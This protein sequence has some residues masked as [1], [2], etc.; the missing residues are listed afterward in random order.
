MGIEGLV[1]FASHKD[2]SSDKSLQAPR[3][4]RAILVDCGSMQWFLR[5][6]ADLYVKHTGTDPEIADAATDFLGFLRY[7]GFEP[8]L[9]LDGSAGSASIMAKAETRDAR[10]VERHEGTSSADSDRNAWRASLVGGVNPGAATLGSAAARAALLTAA[11]RLGVV[12]VETKN[13][14]DATIAWAAAAAIPRA[15]GGVFV[16]SNDGDVVVIPDV[17]VV[18]NFT[19][20][21]NFEFFRF[22]RRHGDVHANLCFA[23]TALVQAAIV[24]RAADFLDS[25]FA[26]AVAGTAL[27]A[28]VPVAA[29]AGTQTEADTEE[30]DS[31]SDS[32]SD[33]LLRLARPGGIAAA[34]SKATARAEAA[35]RVKAE[36]KAQAAADFRSGLAKRALSQLPALAAVTSN[37]FVKCG[38]VFCTRAR[39]APDV[40]TA[41]RA[42]A[43]GSHA[44]ERFWAE[45]IAQQGDRAREWLR[46]GVYEKVKGDGG[47]RNMPLLL[48]VAW[49]LSIARRSGADHADALLKALFSTSPA[50][51]YARV[52]LEGSL[53]PLE[54][55]AAALMRAPSAPAFHLRFSIGALGVALQVLPDERDSGVA[56]DAEAT[57]ADTAVRRRAAESLSY[58]ATDSFA[59]ASLMRAG[60]TIAPIAGTREPC[61]AALLAPLE[62]RHL[63]YRGPTP[64][65]LTAASAGGEEGLEAAATLATLPLPGRRIVAGA[66]YA[67][68]HPHAAPAV[69][70]GVEAA[71]SVLVGPELPPAAAGEAHT[72]ASVGATTATLIDALDDEPVDVRKRH[73]IAT[74]N[75]LVARA[76]TSHRDTTPWSL[77]SSGAPLPIPTQRLDTTYATPPVRQLVEADAVVCTLRH[78][79]AYTVDLVERAEARVAHFTPDRVAGVHPAAYLPT[80]A[81]LRCLA[82]AA[83]KEL[84][85]TPEG[86][87]QVAELRDLGGLVVRGPRAAVSPLESPVPVRLP[88]TAGDDAAARLPAPLQPEDV[89]AAAAH[90]K[91]RPVPPTPR[92]Q[93]IAGWYLAVREEVDDIWAALRVAVLDEPSPY[94]VGDGGD[95]GDVASAQSLNLRDDLATLALGAPK[96]PR[97]GPPP[98]CVKVSTRLLQCMREA[99]S[100]REEGVAV[101]P[102]RAQA[103]EHEFCTDPVLLGALNCT[104]LQLP[105]PPQSAACA[106]DGSGEPAAGDGALAARCTPP[107]HATAAMP[108]G[109]HS[110]LARAVDAVLAA[111]FAPFGGEFGAELT[112]VYNA[113]ASSVADNGGF[114]YYV[115]VGPGPLAEDG[116]PTAAG[117]ARSGD[118]AAAAA[119]SPDAVDADL[120]TALAAGHLPPPARPTVA[121]LHLGTVTGARIARNFLAY[122]GV[123]SLTA[124]GLGPLE[125]SAGVSHGTLNQFVV[126]A[127]DSGDVL[128][129]ATRRTDVAGHGAG[130]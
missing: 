74:V 33:C 121:S 8:V 2:F 10:N 77:G 55:D 58:R 126:A 83:L 59:P 95:D 57:S 81:E 88:V 94:V 125:A 116:L 97:A 67:V 35:A 34:Q 115:M 72:G 130:H 42:A 50:A 73:A 21:S 17:N 22:K 56:A 80:R 104:A 29:G 85:L 96:P 13:E 128:L 24:E 117:A 60:D 118:A 11:L 107:T 28:G 76:A 38:G 52:H 79:V 19:A 114:V 106:G 26:A 1:S 100:E 75:T 103:L 3:E 119:I 69:A 40:S 62:L 86:L 15:A 14:A 45:F 92:Q 31:G 61:T 18:F 16:L 43:A 120:F 36:R 110:P 47:K 71:V 32:D 122:R 63:A 64:A 93:Q 70:V 5:D 98:K 101:F 84:A 108:A 90:A 123:A 49:Y 66:I 25:E 4:H 68:G 105:V 127:F 124:S 129:A 89:A 41:V 46:L 12:A 91:P 111:V 27:A 7:A 30:H 53:A 82:A 102:V 48:G 109:N 65:L 39:D 6:L 112:C 113:I 37:D 20:C 9:V 51:V 44:I 54:F 99:S 23:D 78:L 87:L